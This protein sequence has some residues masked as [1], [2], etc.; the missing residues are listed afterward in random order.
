LY[1]EKY[2]STVKLTF[3]KGAA[4]KDPAGLFNSS[5]ERNV[6]R[7]IDLFEGD[8]LDEEAFKE[9]LLAAVELNRPRARKLGP[10]LVQGTSGQVFVVIGRELSPAV[11][12]TI[13]TRLEP[14]R[15]FTGLAQSLSS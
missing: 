7:A 15:E 6:R 8:T 12:P 14:P 5:L 1:R 9:L 4:L 11:R 13:A 3:A 10:I 2:K